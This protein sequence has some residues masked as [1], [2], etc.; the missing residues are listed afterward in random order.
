MRYLYPL[1][2]LL[3]SALVACAAPTDRVRG[4]ARRE[5]PI[6]LRD[7]GVILVPVRFGTSPVQRLILDTGMSFDGVLLWKPLPDSSVT[8]PRFEVRIPGAGTGEPARGFMAESASFSAGSVEFESQRL[9]WLVDTVMSGF[10]S[11]GVMG[12]SLFGH[13]QVEL[14]YDRRVIVLH[15]SGS[16]R[17]D[18]SWTMLPMTLH[19][20]KM[21]WVE[22][23]ASIQGEEPTELNSYLDLAAGDE[24][25]FLVQDRARFRM[26]EDLEPVNLGR[27]L[28]GDVT[29]W[30]G[31]AASLAL[32]TFRFEDVKVT[33]APEESRSKQPGADA[34]ICGGF[35]SRFNTVYD[36]AGEK[37][38]IRRRQQQEYR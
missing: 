4:A 3:V 32:D 21:P 30:K 24:V 9:I 14:D 18:S 12:Y 33:F 35:L 6:E 13:W 27:G 34:V 1:L 29:G 36:Y 2:L 31:R 5:I 10:P 38:Y 22:L 20:N 16:F 19:K 8:G 23:L 26:P 37:L 15:D 17:P 25:V 28:S 7:N 11:D